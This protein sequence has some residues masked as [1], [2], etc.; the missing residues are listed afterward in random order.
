MIT[1]EQII[2]ENQIHREDVKQGMKVAI[3]FLSF[4]GRKHD[5]DKDIPENAE[6]L[7]NALNT[8]KWE[9]WD[10]KHMQQQR[11]H[12]EGFNKLED[13]DLFDLI[14]MVVDG[15]VA[16]LRRTGK[17]GTLKDQISFFQKK[18]FDEN[19]SKLLANTF[20][21]VQNLINLED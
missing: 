7:A 1:T 18:G 21:R 20:I 15:C 16:N 17:E 3:S 8:N 19:M 14:E 12:V 9:D 2:Q 10:K 11:H 5:L 6:M 4:K 13:G